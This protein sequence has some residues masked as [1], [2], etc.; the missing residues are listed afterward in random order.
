MGMWYTGLPQWRRV[1]IE[2][3]ERDNHT[4][5]IRG[6]K[7]TGHA[8]AVDHIIPAED[9]GALFDLAN[10]RAACT[11]CNT[12]RAQRQKSRDGWRRGRARVILV[13]GPPGSGKSTY[14]ASRRRPGDLVIDYDAL[15]AAM[16]G[17]PH[18]L[19]MAAR[20]S[21]LTRVRRGEVDADQVFIHSTNAHAESMFPHHE[22]VVCD[23]GREE[24]LRRCAKE[25]PA[26]Y[27]R[28]VE[29]WYA[30]REGQAQTREW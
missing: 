12:W 27:V 22:V 26:S 3:L 30:E 24:V 28:I 20:N 19:V 10:L 11:N 15:Q 7:C 29:D 13:M 16:G 2:V 4:C 23:P 18:E 1:R 6:P 21:L 9:G 5:R 14:I 25:R 8:T 17:A